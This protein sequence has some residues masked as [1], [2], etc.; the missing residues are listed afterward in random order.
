M[1]RNQTKKNFHA[2]SGATYSDMPPRRGFGFYYFWFYK[3]TAPDGAKTIHAGF[4][5]NKPR[6]T[7]LKF[8]FRE[9]VPPIG[10]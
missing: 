10:T 2:P 1:E 7:A 5:T 8:A 4:S 6:L 3:Y 9:N